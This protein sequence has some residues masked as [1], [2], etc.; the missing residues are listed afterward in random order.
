MDRKREKGNEREKVRM[1]KR[2]KNYRI[3]RYLLFQQK[4]SKEL[5][6]VFG[7]LQLV[8]PVAVILK[9]K[10]DWIFRGNKGSV[11]NGLDNIL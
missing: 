8:V 10:D 9:G 2:E 5:I 3:I 6:T 7:H 4:I 11:C 1:R